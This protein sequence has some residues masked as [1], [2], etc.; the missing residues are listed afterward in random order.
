MTRRF[1]SWQDKDTI[2]MQ[3]MRS[4]TTTLCNVMTAARSTSSLSH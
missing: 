3:M 4:V 2:D 1:E